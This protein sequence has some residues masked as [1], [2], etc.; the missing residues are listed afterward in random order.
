[1]GQIST[2]DEV[3]IFLSAFHVKL[4]CFDIIF[5][6]NRGKNIQALLDLE[7]T[8]Y[9][10]KEIIAA[11]KKEDYSEGPKSDELYH[12]RDMWV[13]GKTEKGK[14]IYIKISMGIPNSSTICISFHIAERP[15]SYPYK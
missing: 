11:L 14:K 15:M 6:D 2:A 10:R 5:R 4:K 3:S 8:P 7:I 12:S 1:M 9:R 13:F